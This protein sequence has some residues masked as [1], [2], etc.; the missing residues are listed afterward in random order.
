MKLSRKAIRWFRNTS[1]HDQAYAVVR[2]MKRITKSSRWLYMN[3]RC[4]ATGT[5]KK[6]YFQF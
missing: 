6:R 5:Y 4:L 2:K 3:Y 1:K